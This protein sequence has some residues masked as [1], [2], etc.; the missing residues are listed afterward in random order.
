MVLLGLLS[1][2]PCPRPPFLVP[3]SFFFFFFHAV[4]ATYRSSQTMVRLELQLW[5]IP[6]PW[7]HR[8]QATSATHAT[9]C[10]NTTSL[11][12]WA[13]PGIELTPSWTLCQVFYPLIHNRNS[14]WF[15]F[16]YHPYLKWNIISQGLLCHLTFPPTPGEVHLL[17]TCIGHWY[18]RIP[19]LWIQLTM[20]EKYQKYLEKNPRNFQKAKLKFATHWQLLTQHLC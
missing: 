10:G 7:Q 14:S 1:L 17:Y 16:T 11:T 15:H 6:Q 4:P 12:H 13:R 18:L 3:F 20:L 9:A 19:H 2:T 8:I 5:S